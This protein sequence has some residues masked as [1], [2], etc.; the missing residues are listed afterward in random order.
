MDFHHLFADPDPSVFLDE[1]PDPVVFL[2]RTGSGFKNFVNNYGNLR[3][4]WKLLNKFNKI[5]II[6]NF[7]AFLL[8]FFTFFHLNPDPGGKIK[9][10]AD[11]DPRSCLEPGTFFLLK[12]KINT[13]A[14]S[15]V[16]W[17]VLW[18]PPC[19][20]QIVPASRTSRPPGSGY[21]PKYRYMG[22]TT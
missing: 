19:F 11:P 5:I 17:R 10:N 20:Y 2:I 15:L 9:M 13:W 16:P 6:I 8:K 22:S 7:L 12:R 1:D 4:F 3:F 21:A 18:W 14:R